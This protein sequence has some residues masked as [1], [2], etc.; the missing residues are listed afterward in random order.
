LL[1]EF[2]GYGVSIGLKAKSKFLNG[3]W[4]SVKTLFKEKK[5]DRALKTEPCPCK[6]GRRR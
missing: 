4:S 2:V 6:K 5:K 3:N 1:F